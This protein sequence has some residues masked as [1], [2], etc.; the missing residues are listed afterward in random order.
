ME[1]VKTKHLVFRGKECGDMWLYIDGSIKILTY[2]KK[3]TESLKLRLEVMGFIQ[4]KGNKL[5]FWLN[6]KEEI[7]ND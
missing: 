4:D 3:L 6:K 1:V 5:V 2:K 7:T